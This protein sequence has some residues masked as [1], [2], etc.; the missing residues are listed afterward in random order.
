MCSNYHKE[1]EWAKGLTGFLEVASVV[2]CQVYP[3]NYKYY[4]QLEGMGMSLVT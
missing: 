3:I 2:E 4:T 1:P